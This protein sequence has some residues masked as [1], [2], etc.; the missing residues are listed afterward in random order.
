[1]TTK[2]ALQQANIDLTNRLC[3]AN[4]TIAELRAQV[5][6]GDMR[7]KR[8]IA[9]HNR[10]VPVADNKPQRE[11]VPGIPGR[12]EALAKAKAAAMALPKNGD[13]KSVAA[14]F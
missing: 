1:M 13:I 9:A 10:R 12:A 3:E 2:H 6:E 5:A 11:R 14:E 8:L 7:A 4:R